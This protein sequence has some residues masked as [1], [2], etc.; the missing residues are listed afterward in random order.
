MV[1]PYVIEAINVR[2][3]ICVLAMV[4]G[5]IKAKVDPA[6]LRLLNSNMTQ[7][8]DASDKRNMTP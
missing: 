8:V 6:R 7:D 1:G 3:A 2:A 5:S 4:L